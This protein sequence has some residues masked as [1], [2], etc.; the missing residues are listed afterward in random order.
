MAYNRMHVLLNIILCVLFALP[1]ISRA[2]RSRTPND[3]ISKRQSATSA[4]LSVFA[5]YEPVLTPTGSSDQYGCI[6]TELLMDHVFGYS[7]GMP[8]VGTRPMC[9]WKSLETTLLIG[10]RPRKLHTSTMLLQSRHDELYRD[11]GWQ[12]VRPAW[13]NVSWGY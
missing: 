5:V 4:L 9:A 13:H 8:F 3:E 12:A 11:L 10:P 6:Y 7:Y 1:S 2:S